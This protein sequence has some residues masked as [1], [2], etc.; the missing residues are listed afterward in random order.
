MK[1]YKISLFD[2]LLLLLVVLAGGVAYW[3]LHHTT[4]EQPTTAETVLDDMYRSAER[5]TDQEA[6][7][8]T[9][10]YVV[11]YR[12]KIENVDED[13]LR[14]L[15][16]EYTSVYNVY[17]QG[18]LGTLKSVTYSEQDGATC[19]E[20]TISLYSRFYRTYV[21]GLAS[22]TKVF[23]GGELSLQLEDGSYIGTGTVTWMQH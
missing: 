13:H 23:V 4:V 15:L 5:Y 8:E 14:Q 18:L 22:N 19:A 16:K 2:L 21:V 3:Q 17:G 10:D 7:E 20:L 12:L 1:R 6:M 11:D 9:A